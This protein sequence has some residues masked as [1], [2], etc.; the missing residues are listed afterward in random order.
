MR[1]RT[2]AK[3]IFRLGLA[4]LLPLFGGCSAA[5][6]SELVRKY[7]RALEAF[8]QAAAPADYLRSAALYQEILDRGVVSGSLL[9]N[10][11]NAFMRAGQRGRAIACYRQ[12]LAYRPRDPQLRANLQLALGPGASLQP[13]RALLD[14]VF[15]WQDWISYPGKVQATAWLASVA[16]GLGIL[17]I[18]VPPRRLFRR[19]GWAV[20][21]LTTILAASAVYDWYRFEHLE[22]GVV[23]QTEVVAR[24]GNAESYAPAFTE[25]LKEGTEF[26]VL[27]RRGTWLQ[28]QLP[29]GIAGWVPHAAVT[30]F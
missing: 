29:G 22:H 11:G 18:F 21:A 2:A 14:Y 13:P 20:L 9:Y 15:F 24:K 19:I 7:Q 8:D 1:S 10:Q 12:A 28:I 25:P 26:L 3:A 30:T 17:A 6:E 27:E 4:A 5:P 16:F 23:V